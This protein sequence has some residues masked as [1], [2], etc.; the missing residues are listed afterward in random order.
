MLMVLDKKQLVQWTYGLIGLK[1]GQWRAWWQLK[2]DGD[3]RKESEPGS[4]E[5]L[6]LDGCEGLVE[7][8]CVYEGAAGGMVTRRLRHWVGMARL[9]CGA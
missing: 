5:D 1:S 4:W 8:A 3:L 6:E 7:G 2:H 9:C